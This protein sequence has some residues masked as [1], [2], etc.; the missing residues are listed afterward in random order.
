[1]PSV[2]VLGAGDLGGAI[3][4]A[5][6]ERARVGSILLVDEQQKVAAGKA[7]DIQQGAAVSQSPDFRPC[8]RPCQI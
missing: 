2:A 8:F 5:L 1:M 7:L 3:A 6:T 4:H